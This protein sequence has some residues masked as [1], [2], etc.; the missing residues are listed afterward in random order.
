MVSLQL[1]LQDFEQTETMRGTGMPLIAA[2]RGVLEDIVGKERWGPN[3]LTYSKPKK[4]ERRMEK[5][6]EKTI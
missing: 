2:G 4:C 1:Y 3:C 5:G 6:V